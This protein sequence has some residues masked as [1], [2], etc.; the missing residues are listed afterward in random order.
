MKRFIETFLVASILVFLFSLSSQAQLINHYWTQNFNSTSSLIGGAVV[1]GDGDNSSIYYN[2]ATIVEMEKGSNVSLAANLFS[3]NVYRNYNALGNG[4]NLFNTNFQVQPQFVSFTYKPPKGNVSYAFSVLTRIKEDLETEFTKSQDY[5]VLPSFPG[6]EMYTGAFSYRNQYSDTWVGL[7][8]G[9][10]L[11]NGFSYGVTLFVS[12][13]GLI[14]HFGYTNAV[15]KFNDSTNS[16]YDNSSVSQSAY[17]ESIKFYQYRIISKLG[18]A[19]KH[20]KWRFGLVVTVPSLNVFSSGRV[21]S[22]SQ[23]Q[24][25]IRNEEGQLVSDYVIFS[26]QKAKQLTANY[27]YPFAASFGLIREF[28]DSRQKLY[29]TMEY[30]NGIKP[31]SL[32]GADVDPNITSPQVYDTMQNKNYLS[33][34]YKA[35][36]I[37]NFA[38]GYSWKIKD[39]LTF[40]NAFRT[41]FTSVQNLTSAEL[42]GYNFMKTATYNVYHYS[43]GLN[44]T[45]KKNTFIA[46]GEFSFGY[47]DKK[48]QIANFNDPVEYNPDTGV[49]LQGPQQNTAY[50]RYYGVSVYISA[51]LNFISKKNKE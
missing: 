14:Y 50:L 37:F 26:T 3:W 35:D 23:V 49:A 21:A 17:E 41:D 5:D 51:T 28:R 4:N 39:G 31:Y 1:A 43:A 38:L 42:N 45:F 20:D 12:A 15:Y 33:F 25:N 47:T 36:P 46:G 13:S 34:A 2:P 32:V 19:F 18:L 44:F 24:S 11:K 7:G 9:Q 8:L 16:S 48:A 30:F 22:R 27:K 40:L 10:Q 29:F 6:K